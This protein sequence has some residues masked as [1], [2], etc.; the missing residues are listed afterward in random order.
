MMMRRADFS[1]IQQ[2][3]EEMSSTKKVSFNWA[4]L[5]PK[6]EAVPQRDLCEFPAVQ[7]WSPA[8]Y[9][10]QQVFDAEGAEGGCEG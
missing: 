3:G 5:I 9:H 6:I 4:E 2:K 7:R 1:N 10:R 8:S